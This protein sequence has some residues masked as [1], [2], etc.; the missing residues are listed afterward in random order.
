MAW[1][2]ADA[3]SHAIRS[4]TRALRLSRLAAIRVHVEGPA[5][6]GEPRCLDLEL[7]RIAVTVPMHG[8]VGADRNDAFTQAGTLG[9]GRRREHHIPLLTIDPN[10]HRRV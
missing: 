10:L 3:S 2:S 4:C 6:P 7:L 8:H 5:V 9:A 1:P